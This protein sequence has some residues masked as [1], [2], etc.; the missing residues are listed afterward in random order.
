MTNESTIDTF[1]PDTWD[2]YIGQKDAKE[3]L[4]K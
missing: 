1:V 2:G 3:R 4:S